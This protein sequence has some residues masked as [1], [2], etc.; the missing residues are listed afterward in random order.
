M[1]E[2]DLAEDDNEA[3]QHVQRVH[4]QKDES[5]KIYLDSCTACSTFV[6]EKHLMQVN[7]MKKGLAV[8]CN[9]GKITTKR[10]RKFGRLNVWAMKEGIANVISLGELV[11]LYRVTFDSLDGFFRRTHPWRGGPLHLGQ[12]GDAGP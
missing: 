1:E 9:A 2:L 5:N 3:Q 10:R 12:T 7:D 4:F 6:G 11:Q 8:H